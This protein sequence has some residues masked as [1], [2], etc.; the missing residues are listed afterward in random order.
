MQEKNA[1]FLMGTSTIGQKASQ[2]RQ[3][4]KPQ[5]PNVPTWGNQPINSSPLA[6]T[7][8]QRAA[9]VQNA[10][11]SLNRQEVLASQSVGRGMAKQQ[12]PRNRQR[13]V[14][15]NSFVDA[16]GVARKKIPASAWR[17]QQAA[18]MGQYGGFG[19]NFQHFAN[20]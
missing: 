4:F 6:V 3:A 14:D 17:S 20:F 9:I 16:A 8:D 1:N 2:L 15:E 18:S 5:Q 19:S 7:R 13:P 12:A 10:P 11:P